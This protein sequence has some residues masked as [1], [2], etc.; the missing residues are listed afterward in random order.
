MSNLI[1]CHSHIIDGTD[2]TWTCCCQHLRIVIDIESSPTMQCFSHHRRKSK[3][4]YF[5]MRTNIVTIL[6]IPRQVCLA[7]RDTSLCILLSM[8]VNLFEISG[9]NLEEVHEEVMVS[10]RFPIMAQL[11]RSATTDQHRSR[12][13]EGHRCGTGVRHF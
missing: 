10:S 2:C 11:M 4:S 8:Y 3:Q 7:C 13:P 12:A 9:I 5:G 1:T 6:S